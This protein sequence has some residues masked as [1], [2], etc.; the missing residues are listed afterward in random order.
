MKLTVFRADITPPLGHPLCAGWYPEMT[1]VDTPLSANGIVLFP[2]NDLPLVL[3]ALD[4]AEL[5]NR[6]HQ[7][8]REDLAAAAGTHADRVAVHCLHAHDAPWPDTEAQDILVRQ[9]CAGRIMEA[10]W[11]DQVRAD[12][13]RSIKEA[14]LHVEVVTGLSA[15]E[16]EVRGVASNRRVIGPDGKSR[17]VRWT[18]CLDESLRNEPEGVIDP[19]LRSLVLWG[20]D[21]PLAVLHYYTVHPTSYDRTGRVTPDFVGLAR[22][23]LREEDG[24]AHL[25]FTQCAGN[26]TTGKYNDGDPAWRERFTEEIYQAMKRSLAASRPMELT[27]PSWQTCPVVLP[28]GEIPPD[29]DLVATIKNPAETLRFQSRAALFLAYRKRVSEGRP[30]LLQLLS[31]G[32]RVQIL[33]LP[34]EA[35]VE[36]QLFAQQLRPNS[37]MAVPAYGDCGPGYIPLARSFAEGG[38]EPEDAF[39]SAESEAVLKSAMRQLL[40][41][42]SD[43][44]L[45]A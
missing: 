21:R 34:A 18:R 16:A 32:P 29:G 39:C 19:L 38:Y 12:V 42:P 23:R 24:V 30:L 27:E 31:F 28:A 13:A 41:S 3:C 44:G 11:C 14:F 35:F 40:C 37:W 36:Y 45:L 4:W 20:D 1:G 10:A 43:A 22:E 8:W 15:G 26:I 25:Y 6:D 5:S 7:Q 2:N 33:H 9:G 17:G